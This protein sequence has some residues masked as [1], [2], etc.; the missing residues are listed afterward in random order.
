MSR[1]GR[2]TT[3]TIL[4]GMLLV[5][6]LTLASCTTH[7]DPKPAPQTAA[8]WTD[9]TGAACD[10]LNTAARPA[11]VLLFI[12][13]DCPISN[14]YAREIARIANRYG[15]QGVSFFAVHADPRVSAEVAEQHA[16]EYGYRFPVLLDPQ[17]KLAL[18]V[19][20]T[21]TP[22][23]AVLD[24]AGNVVYLGRIDDT[25]VSFGHRRATPTTHELRD[26]LDAVLAN[27]PVAQARVPAIGCEIPPPPAM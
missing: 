24:R 7:S 9:V 11:T 12:A 4:C 27:R 21:M 10:P 20:A 5:A 22:Q 2:T 14:A 16:K 19:G 15:P 26:A 3:K 18:R 13:P 25:F 17:Q 1:S 8:T 6:M 23:A